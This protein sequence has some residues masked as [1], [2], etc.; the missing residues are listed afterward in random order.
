[1]FKIQ[2]KIYKDILCNSMKFYKFPED[3]R[4]MKKIIKQE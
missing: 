3:H 4:I 1:M 2:K